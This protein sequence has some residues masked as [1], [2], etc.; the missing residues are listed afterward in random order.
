MSSLSYRLETPRSR[1]PPLPIR[2]SNLPIRNSQILGQKDATETLLYDLPSS[3][4]TSPTRATSS[5]L[6]TSPTSPYSPRS[7]SARMRMTPPPYGGSKHSR[8][9]TPSQPMRSELEEFAEHCR[10]WYV[11]SCLPPSPLLLG[12]LNATGIISRTIMPAGS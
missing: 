5:S 11:S 9:N 6:P 8:S 4:P 2:T 3:N 1:P 7:R 10:A 12:S